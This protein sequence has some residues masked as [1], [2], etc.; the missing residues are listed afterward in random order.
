MVEQVGADGKAEAGG[1]LCRE[2]AAADS[3]NGAG[4]R[5]QEHLAADG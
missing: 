4:Q 3:Q 1:R 5:T 2:I